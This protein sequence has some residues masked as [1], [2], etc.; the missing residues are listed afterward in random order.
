ME[1]KDNHVER[2]IDLLPIL[3]AL[4][5]KLWLMI[6]IGVIFAG[7]AFGATKLLVK[8]TYRCS[9]TAYV[10]NQHAQGSTDKLTSSDL[11]AS[12]QLGATYVRILKSNTILTA[13]LDSLD[14]DLTYGQFSRM[15]SA[16][17]QGDTEVIA[18]YVV[19][20][21]PQTAYIL[22]NALANTAPT[23]MTQIVEGSSMK[24]IDYP[25]FSDK[26]YKPSYTKYALLGFLAGLLLVA[27]IVI[28]RYLTDD[29]IKNEHDIEQR[30][31]IPILGIIPDVLQSAENKGKGYYAYEYGYGA[32]RKQSSDKGGKEK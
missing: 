25:M 12:Q 21:D 6:L 32:K 30:F 17:V 8:P 31:A 10:N 14:L 26:R 7:M 9:F 15:V 5:S 18:V 27:V 16:E 2:E 28:I 24:I 29:K 13:A 20:G 11:N 4:L 22:A 19:N 3:K 23:Y 1:N